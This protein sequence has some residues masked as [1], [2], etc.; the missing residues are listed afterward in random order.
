MKEISNK[1]KIQIIDDL[2]I[3]SKKFDDLSSEQNLKKLNNS[4]LKNLMILR[5]VKTQ[6]KANLASKRHDRI[7][8]F[9]KKAKLGMK[10]DL[11]EYKDFTSNIFK[12]PKYSD[13]QPLFSNLNSLSSYDEKSLL[14]D[15]KLIELLEEMEDE[16]DNE[17]GD[18][19][20]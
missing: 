7:M 9:L 17:M 1:D 2:F 14:L 4:I 11:E 6:S 12:N 10:N 3:E 13:L 19:K 16:F 8:E 18:D 20:N 15:A 5:R